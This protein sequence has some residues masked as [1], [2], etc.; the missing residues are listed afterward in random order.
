MPEPLTPPTE[1]AID[2]VEVQNSVEFGQLRRTLR[3]F[4]FPLAAVSLAWYLVFVL[5]AAYA[6]SV[7][8][9][10]VTEN[11]TLGLILGL[12]QFL[13]VFVVTGWY[14]WY[15]NRKLDPPATT[16]RQELERMEAG[17]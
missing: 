7:M 14:V 17:A 4:V 6:P 10:R 2:Y 5:L 13:W 1:G 9:I 11:I 16:L 8:D 3:V 15:A 12:S